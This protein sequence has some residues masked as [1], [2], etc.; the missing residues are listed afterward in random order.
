VR[1][2]M[3]QVVRRVQGEIC[4]AVSAL[5]GRA[6]LRDE[7]ARVGGGGGVSCVLQ[8][9]EVFEKAGVNVSVVE[10]VLSPE[11]ARAMGGGSAAGEED[12][13]FFAAGLSVVI[14]PRNPMAPT[15]HCNY[16]YFERGGEGR[17]A[18]RWFGGGS[19]LTPSYL[20]EEDARHFHGILKGACDRHDAAFYPR[21]KAWCDEYFLLPHR[22]E[23]RGLGGIFFDD[24]HDR[25]AQDLLSFVTDC[26]EAFVPSY[27]P[28]VS[29]HLGEPFTPEQKRWQALRRGRYVEF[30]LLQDR[31]TLFGLRTGGRIESILMSLPLEARWE[32]AHEPREGSAEA[33]LMAVLRTPRDWA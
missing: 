3:E 7:W 23:R 17:P 20:V 1:K 14:H 27:V 32:Y 33:A 10:G 8:D 16:R 25:P 30:N 5:E 21:F 29:A 12:L 11:A 19:D 18:A 22:G 26:A 15:A 13:R 6:F 28:L 2:L 31:G 9:G 24:L 4:E